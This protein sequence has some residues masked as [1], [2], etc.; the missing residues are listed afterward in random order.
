[1]TARKKA[2]GTSNGEARQWM[3]KQKFLRKDGQ[4][5]VADGLWEL[6]GSGESWG[7]DRSPEEVLV[8]LISTDPTDPPLPHRNYLPG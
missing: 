1:M 2:M 3:V 7:K 4:E 8:S 6:C 5:G